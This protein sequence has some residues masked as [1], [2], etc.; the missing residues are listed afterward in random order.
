MKYANYEM[1]LN[2]VFSPL[3]HIYS[4]FGIHA[5]FP[6]AC[7]LRTQLPPEY[8]TSAGSGSSR[9]RE[10]ASWY[11]FIAPAKLANAYTIMCL[12]LQNVMQSR[13][14]TCLCLSF[15]FANLIHPTWWSFGSFLN[16]V[17]YYRTFVQK[18]KTE[19]NESLLCGHS[20]FVIHS[21]YVVSILYI[22]VTTS[23]G[24]RVLCQGWNFY[25]S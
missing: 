10:Y 25:Y 7:A 23:S 15:M 9:L 13:M 6:S 20:L 21:G 5:Y 17:W 24:C 1:R 16:C 18:K 14:Y 4:R 22:N 3:E 19:Q 12:V 11:D 8:R 2:D